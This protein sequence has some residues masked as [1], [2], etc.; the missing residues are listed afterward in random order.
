LEVFTDGEELEKHMFNPTTIAKLQQAVRLSPESYKEYSTMVNDQSKNLMTIRGLFE[1]NN[2]S[3]SIDEVEPWT[4]IVKNLKLEPCL[5]D[6]SVRKP[7]KTWQCH[8]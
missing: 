5:M 2:G 4:E 3:I 1:F 6:R 7:M 8:E